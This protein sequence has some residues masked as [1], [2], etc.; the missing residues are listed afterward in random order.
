MVTVSKIA[1]AEDAL[2]AALSRAPPSIASLF[3]PVKYFREL[4]AHMENDGTI[5][6]QLDRK[7][8]RRYKS[9]NRKNRK[10]SQN[11]PPIDPEK[12]LSVLN[13]IIDTRFCITAIDDEKVYIKIFVRE[14]KL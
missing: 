14:R 11:P 8:F 7:F 2:L 12:I 3:E 10:L 9:Y 5:S 13:S 1:A 4:R 6:M